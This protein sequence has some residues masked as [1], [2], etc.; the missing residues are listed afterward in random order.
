MKYVAKANSFGIHYITLHGITAPKRENYDG[1][2]DE[3]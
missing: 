1:E 3:E 2:K